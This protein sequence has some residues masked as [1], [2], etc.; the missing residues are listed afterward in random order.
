MALQRYSNNKIPTLV[1]N[2]SPRANVD[3]N[4]IIEFDSTH[5]R[6]TIFL[7]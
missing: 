7:R 3:I 4:S 5:I 6:C 2:L 1:S